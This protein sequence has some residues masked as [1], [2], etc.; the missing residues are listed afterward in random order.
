MKN[1]AA[2]TNHKKTAPAFLAVL[3]YLTIAS[4]TELRQACQPIYYSACKKL[5]L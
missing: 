2:K 3:F 4:K 5:F 1:F